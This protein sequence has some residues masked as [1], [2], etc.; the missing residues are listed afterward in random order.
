MESITDNDKYKLIEGE[1]YIYISANLDLQ[2]DDLLEILYQEVVLMLR[3]AFSEAI[4]QSS[5]RWYAETQPLQFALLPRF[6]GSYSSVAF[7]I[8]FY[9]ILDTKIDEVANSMFPCEIE[10]A[11]TDYIFPGKKKKTWI[12][13]ITA[14]GGI[15]THLERYQQVLAV[16]ISAECESNYEEFKTETIESARKFWNEFSLS[17]EI[18]TKLMSVPIDNYNEFVQALNS[19]YDCFNEIET[20]IMENQNPKELINYINVMIT[21]MIL[22]S[23]AVDKLDIESE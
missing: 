23:S 6:D 13:S 5:I 7:S 1:R 18:T 8:P 20:C 12:Q 10:P 19:I 2:G 3:E 14:L 4:L 11:L 9:R 21:G 17:E 22:L 15:K 16:R